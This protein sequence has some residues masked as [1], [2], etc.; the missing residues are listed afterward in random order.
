MTRSRVASRKSPPP[1][2]PAIVGK[3]R[4][5][6]GSREEPHPPPPP[7]VPPPLP[8]PRW[9]ST[10]ADDVTAVFSRAARGRIFPVIET[11]ER[12]RVRDLAD[13]GRVGVLWGLLLGDPI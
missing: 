13:T 7:L 5:K 12:I 4:G 8:T 9:P 11:A 2:L 1:A 3:P 6:K 10:W